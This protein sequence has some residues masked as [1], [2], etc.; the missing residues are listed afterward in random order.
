MHIVYGTKTCGYCDQAKSLLRRH[1]LQWEYVDLKD[2][3]KDDQDE[4]MRIAGVQFRT[5]P[6]IFK[7]ESQDIIIDKNMTYV[8]DLTELK[9][10]LND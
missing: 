10:L 4:L 9:D 1:G 2:L 6:Q 7:K 8:G 3:D 5:V